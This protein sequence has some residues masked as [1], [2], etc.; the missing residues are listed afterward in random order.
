MS[1]LI[2]DP[3]PSSSRTTGAAALRQESTFESG[4]RPLG[5]P[6]PP[7]GWLHEVKHDGFRAQGIS[8]ILPM[9]S[10]D[11]ISRCASEASRIG[12]RR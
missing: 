3:L 8:R 1:G 12:K 10:L 6:L 5:L 4:F 7:P 2:D 11:S 9:C